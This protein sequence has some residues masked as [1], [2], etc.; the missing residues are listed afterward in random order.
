MSAF[1]PDFDF[2]NPDYN[3]VFRARQDVLFATMRHPERWEAAKGYYKDHWADFLE[4][5]GMTYDPRRL[6]HGE[7]A[8]LPFLLFPRQREY[9]YWRYERW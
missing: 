2:K 8:L 4:H 1:I 3:R 7:P 9:V 6:A 5:W